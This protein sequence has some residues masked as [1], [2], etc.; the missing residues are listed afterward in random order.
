MNGYQNIPSSLQKMVQSEL[1]SGEN[2]I[3]MGMPKAEYFNAHSIG[4]FLF[5]IPWTAFSLFW[6]VGASGFKVPDFNSTDILFPLFGLPFVLIGVSMLL[7]PL[8]V[9]RNALKTL[10]VITDRRVIIFE[11]GAKMIRSYEVERL[12]NITRYEKENGYG[13]L[14]FDKEFKQKNIINNIGFINIKDA[15]GVEQKI[16][17]MIIRQERFKRFERE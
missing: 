16:K 14:I 8:R 10:Y 2:I 17:Q 1:E 13:D 12:N 7:T 4:I 9:Y 6:I 11:S 5:A 15:K 3:W